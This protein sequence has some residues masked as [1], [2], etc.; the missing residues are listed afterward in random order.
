MKYCIILIL[1]CFCLWT[2]AQENRTI[3]SPAPKPIMVSTEVLKDKI[4]GGWAGQT[5]GVTFG[6][7]VEFQFQGTMI[8][9]YQPILWYDGYIKKT[10]TE[11][12]GAL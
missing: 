4:R 12:P 1:G 2:N 6:G 5:I 11:N 7:P 10:M 3:K 8:N 9:D